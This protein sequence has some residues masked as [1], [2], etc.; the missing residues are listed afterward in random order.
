[1]ERRWVMKTSIDFTVTHYKMF[2]HVDADTIH[3]CL[4]INFHYRNSNREVKPEPAHQHE[5]N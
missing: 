2:H 4:H 3:T 5:I 1:M